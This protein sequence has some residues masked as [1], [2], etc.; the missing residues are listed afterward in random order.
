MNWFLSLARVTVC[1]S[2]ILIPAVW[3]PAA[4]AA[5][6]T[7]AQG[8]TEELPRR[9]KTAR[10]GSEVMREVLNLSGTAR[11][12]F[13]A[14]EV[15]AGN[16]PD[17]LRDL[18]PVTLSGQGSD[19][20]AIQI[21]ICVTPEYLSVGNDEDYVR[22]PLGLSNAARIADRL[23]FFLPTTKMVDA[24]YQQ[25]QVQL[26]P[27]PMKPTNQM[28]ST[29]YLLRHSHTVDAM[30]AQASRPEGQLTA[31]QKKDLVLST[32]LRRAPG[33]VAIYGWHRKNG[34]PIQPLSTVH[35]AEYA[36]YSHGV[37]LISQTAFIN[38]E[39]RLLADI[40]QDR[41]LA[42]I[43]SSE[44]PISNPAQLMASLYR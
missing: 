5:G 18:T 36:D 24:I 39:P 6:R 43:V 21:T 15:F 38:G 13:V 26:A 10:S 37:R 28:S 40:M 16:V 8:L 27:S 9:Q 25:A 7:C 44:G 20:Q 33:R 2:L 34:R 22:V 1:A 30:R 29:D 31:G 17:F 19:G 14:S 12:A 3:V 42:G 23:G 32:R 35:G 4:E 11:D 41:A